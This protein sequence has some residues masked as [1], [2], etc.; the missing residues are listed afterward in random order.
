[1]DALSHNN[2]VRQ[3]TVIESRCVVIQLR[4]S[5]LWSWSIVTWGT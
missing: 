3:D 5:T 1:M 4:A 2:V